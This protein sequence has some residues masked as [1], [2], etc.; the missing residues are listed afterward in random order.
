MLDVMVYTPTVLVVK[1][2]VYVVTFETVTGVPVGVQRNDCAF[3]SIIVVATAPVG[4]TALTMPTTV[5]VSV[6]TPP[7]VGLEDATTVMIG[8]CFGSVTVAIALVTGR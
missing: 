2:Q 8:V 1:V 7:R 3:G 4:F 6:E 5:V